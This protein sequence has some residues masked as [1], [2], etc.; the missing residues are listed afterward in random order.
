[1]LLSPERMKGLAHAELIQL[2]EEGV[3]TAALQAVH[4]DAIALEGAEMA[5]RLESFFSQA[6]EAPVAASFPYQEPSDLA[7]IQAARRDGPRRRALSEAQARDRILGAWLGRCAGCM[8]GKPVEG[9]SKLEIEALLRHA[10]E[11]P[12]SHYFPPL[13]DAPEGLK[14]YH[15]PGND[16]LRGQTAYGVRDDDTD[17][18]LLGLHVLE[19]YGPGFTPDNVA[20]E[21]LGRL[22]YHRVYT[23][24]REAYRN[25]AV[26]IMPPQS[27]V[28][29]NPYREWIGAQIRCDGF[30]YGAAGWPEKAA[31]YAW[32]DAV[33]SHVKNGI[34]G[35]MFFA[36]AIAAAMATE[37]LEEALAAGRAEVPDNSRLAE[38]V[39]DT[40]AW[41]AQDTDW[42]TTWQRMDEKYGHYHP[43]HTINNAV[44]VILA[45][46]HAQGD[47]E[48][49]ICIS[50]MGGL[51]TD[52]NGA[53]AGS[54]MGALMGA[55]AVPAKWVAPLNDTLYS[56][57]EGMNVSK[58]SDLTARTVK[59]AQRVLAL[60]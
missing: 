15:S 24:E 27:A 54:L 41:C 19:A 58:I 48:K 8:L 52:C 5:V 33:V 22:P 17:Y 26:D 44:I 7:G 11:Y 29:M 31:E 1:M 9:W 35:E 18:T 43:V 60:S 32:R 55:T 53:T 50:V 40:I 4:D 45:C 56:A 16:C 14:V 30:A 46:L 21:W 34:Y 25:L 28:V 59:V 42:Q 37:S 10:G 3:D 38:A 13:A 49:A 20:A 2:K 12:L 23:A 36:A 47:F 51:D 39:D 57:L 6:V